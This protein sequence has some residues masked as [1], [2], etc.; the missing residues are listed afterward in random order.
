MLAP[1]MLVIT[2]ENKNCVKMNI[3]KQFLHSQISMISYIRA[4]DESFCI[5]RGN[6]TRFK[7]IFTHFHA[8]LNET[9]TKENAKN[10]L[11]CKS[12]KYC[13]FCMRFYESRRLYIQ[14]ATR[15]RMNILWISCTYASKHAHTHT[16]GKRDNPQTSFAYTNFGIITYI[17]RVVRFRT[18][19][20]AVEQGI[21]QGNLCIV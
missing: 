1:R 3:R 10:F 21:R 9:F 15:W 16:A 4:N 17:N 2:K 19:L 14:N 5:Q 8:S 12:W 13:T 18:Q 11:N 20:N 6:A 7:R